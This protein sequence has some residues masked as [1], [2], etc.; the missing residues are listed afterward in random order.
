MIETLRRIVVEVGGATD[1]HEALSIIVRRVR[2]AIAVD[3]CSVYLR[4]RDSGDYVL[5]ATEGLNLAAVG[6]ARLAW[7][8]GLVGLAGERQEPINVEDAQAHPRYHF[9]P[10]TGEERYRALLAVP[11]IH[12]RRVLGVLVVRHRD[13]WRFDEDEISFLVTISAQLAAV[14]AGVLDVMLPIVEGGPPCEQGVCV[15][16]GIKGAPGVAVG[17]IVLPS[18]LADLASVPDR[19]IDDITAEERAFAAAVAVVREEFRTSGER[20]ALILPDEV[21]GV[22]EVY[23]MFLGDEWL[24]TNTLRRIRAGNWAAG[25]LR[26]TIIEHARLFEQIEDA[27]LRARAEDIRAIGRR[28]LAALRA[29]AVLPEEYPERCVLVGEEVSIARIADVPPGKLAG[30]VCMR[31]SAFSHSSIMARA[32][33]IPA[34]VGVGEL[35]LRRLEGTTVV[36]DGYQGRVFIQPSAAV[37][38]EYDRLMRQEGV[39]AAALSELRDVPAETTDGVR[40]SLQVN[41]GLLSDLVSAQSCGAEGIGL[42]R[43][44][45]PFM[46]RE[47]FPSEDEQYRIYRQLLEAFAPKPVTLRTLDIGGDKFL[48]YFSIKE[49]NPYLGWRGIRVTLDHP[50]IFLTQLRAMLRASVG[51]GNLQ[52]LFPMISRVAELDEAL[53]LLERAHHG[54]AEE[55]EAALRPRV[56]VM[57]EVPSAVYLSRQ[58]ASRADFLSIG[59]NDLTQYLLAVD[60]NNARVAG[61]YDSLHPAVMRAVH[62]VIAGGHEEGKPVSV[63]GEMAGD[64]G[65]ALL[66]LGMGIDSLSM[67]A[68]SLPR[69]KWAIRSVSL[70][71]ARALLERALQMEDEAAVRLLVNDALERAGAGALVRPAR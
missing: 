3:A 29:E 45:F 14:L 31:G 37:L 18:P 8:E 52:V 17:T 62:D 36:V 61:L 58:L 35:P 71:G 49:D 27:Y 4:E 44:E 67:S 46:V 12:Y 9:L 16:Q 48:P 39:L 53:S 43:T 68:S 50:E 40:V 66:L 69:V 2:E 20:M 21:H 10:Q 15:L 22:F 25:A 7:N 23:S 70:D 63:C 26:D 19:S 28:L 34:V 60:R 54:L 65:A 38:Q 56:G 59:T 5:Q 32:M 42:H 51:L 41:T 47:S 13:Q 64:P 30:V 24:V 11:I 57:I 55:G 6:R 1:L 33:G